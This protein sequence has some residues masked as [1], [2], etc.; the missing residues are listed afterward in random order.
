MDWALAYRPCDLPGGRG[1]SVGQPVLRSQFAEFGQLVARSPRQISA[2]FAQGEGNGSRGRVADPAL[3]E[4]QL[5]VPLA[6]RRRSTR[7]EF[8]HPVVVAVG[9]VEAAGGVHR[10]P[11]LSSSS[12]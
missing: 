3:V 11:A 12:P 1:R 6:R 7:P 8:E 9:D 2:R 10:H 4:P 5:P